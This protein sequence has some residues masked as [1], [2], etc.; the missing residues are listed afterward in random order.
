MLVSGF[1][2]QG[3]SNV[4]FGRIEVYEMINAYARELLLDA[5]AAFGAVGY[6]ISHG[7]VDLGAA[8]SRCQFAAC[9][10]C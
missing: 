5:K 3:V 8:T 10:G 7:I 1:G 9:R 2:Y 4:K 6:R